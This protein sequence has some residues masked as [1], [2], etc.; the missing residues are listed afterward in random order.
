MSAGQVRYTV[1]A[2]IQTQEVLKE[3]VDWLKGGHMQALIDAGA[4]SGEIAIV[5]SDTIKVEV[6]YIFPSRS[7]LQAYFDG[8]ALLLREDG[9]TRFIDTNKVVFSRSIATIEHTL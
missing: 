6:H 2:A 7:V 9:K 3:F 8:P 4:L 1:Y 5:E